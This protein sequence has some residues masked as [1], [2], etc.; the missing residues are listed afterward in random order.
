MQLTQ[1]PVDT[2]PA[3]AELKRERLE[4]GATVTAVKQGTQNGSRFVLD[5]DADANAAAWSHAGW[6][7]KDPLPLRIKGLNP[8]WSALLFTGK[9]AHALPLDNDGTALF[10]LP[11]GGATEIVAGNPVTADDPG[12]A[13]D[14]AGVSERGVS[15]RLHNPGDKAKTF[16]VRSNPAFETVIPPF[17][18]RLALN[19]GAGMWVTAKGDK[20]A[21]DNIR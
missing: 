15:L 11:P 18:F 2:A 9:T 6:T 4:R 16:L 10:A 17:S 19:P 5:F 3:L 21:I 20:L 14:F 1:T 7:G 13:I 8:N 12:L